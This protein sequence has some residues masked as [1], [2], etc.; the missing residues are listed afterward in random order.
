V[1][2]SE[3]PTIRKCVQR[4]IYDNRWG[5][6]TSWI[7]ELLHRDSDI[8]DYNGNPVARR[9]NNPVSRL[10]DRLPSGALTKDSM[11]V[12]IAYLS[13]AFS[14]LPSLSSLWFQ[15]SGVSTSRSFA[16]VPGFYARFLEMGQFEGP[17]WDCLGYQNPP[18][19]SWCVFSA[20]PAMFATKMLVPDLRID[21]VAWDEMFP[22]SH[23]LELLR[24][25]LAPV[26]RFKLSTVVDFTADHS[27]AIP[28]SRSIMTCFSCLGDL[29]LEFR[30][31]RVDV[32]GGHWNWD[33]VDAPN[34][35]RPPFS[36]LL[37]NGIYF[38]DLTRLS[39]FGFCVEET[40]LISFLRPHAKT[41]SVLR[42]GDGNLVPAADTG[43]ESCWVRVIKRLQADLHLKEMRFAQ[44]LGN[45]DS[46]SWDILEF[47]MYSGP[48]CLKERVENFVVHG[49]IC[50]LEDA[51]V[52]VRQDEARKPCVRSNGDDSWRI[53]RGGREQERGSQGPDD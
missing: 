48:G 29:D 46:Q 21:D 52:G 16:N 9:E 47:G 51:A 15:E 50:P 53:W 4:L 39:L 43:F 17:R 2:L 45:Y 1:S 6:F 23:R 41:L 30:P 28:N 3:H 22:S 7:W 35:S 19:G 33:D 11:D 26:R 13:R 31:G 32:P 20:L 5:D 12:E 24:A 38:P 8:L 40:D 25:V 36:G 42:L 49:G 34:M 27:D 18:Q 44:F 10:L 14:M 37:P